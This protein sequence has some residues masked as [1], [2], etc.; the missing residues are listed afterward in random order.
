MS[1]GVQATT[2][3]EIVTE[4]GVAK[5]SFYRYFEDKTDLV[6]V[7]FGPM[8]A[9]EGAFDNCSAALE[10]ADSRESLFAAYQQLGQQLTGVIMANPQLALLYLQEARGPSVG[11][12]A[13]IRRL[14]DTMLDNAVHISRVARDHGLLRDFDPRISALSVVGAVERLLFGVL[15]GY[16][17]GNV[18]EIPDALISMVLD[19]LRPKET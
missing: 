2:I 14:A 12:R 8:A 17:V 11:A 19:G 5:G 13:P 6:E 7:L 15:S 9:M 10:A 16:D 18:A 1:R 3:D 4:A